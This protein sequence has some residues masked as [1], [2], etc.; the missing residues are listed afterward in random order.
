MCMRVALCEVG[1]QLKHL[2]V[3]TNDN[4][5]W[6]DNTFEYHLLNDQICLDPNMVSSCEHL[7]VQGLWGNEGCKPRDFSA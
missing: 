1:Y 7:A 4:F 3:A 6:T 5:S 2:K